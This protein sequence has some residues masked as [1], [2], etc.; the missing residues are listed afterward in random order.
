MSAATNVQENYIYIYITFEF[1]KEKNEKKKSMFEEK[2]VKEEKRIMQLE[3]M[4][5]YTVDNE[6]IDF[7]CFYWPKLH[8]CFCF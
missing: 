7:L 5:C 8:I 2:K 1:R 3:K 4:R 6:H